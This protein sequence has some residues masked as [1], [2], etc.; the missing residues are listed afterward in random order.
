[1]ERVSLRMSRRMSSNESVV[2]FRGNAALRKRQAYSV[3]LRGSS[4]Y[5]I[6]EVKYDLVTAFGHPHGGMVANGFS[7]CFVTL[8]QPEQLPILQQSERPTSYTSSFNAGLSATKWCL[9]RLNHCHIQSC[10][11]PP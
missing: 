8:H 9:P 7:Y 3:Y 4:F 11:C 2:C 5:A 10:F 6:A 1:M